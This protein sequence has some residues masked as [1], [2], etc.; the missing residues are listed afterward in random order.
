MAGF[1][2]GHAT[3]WFNHRERIRHWISR[4][5]FA[6][7]L[8]TPMV[9]GAYFYFD[10]RWL[11]FCGLASLAGLLVS[12]GVLYSVTIV[13][14]PLSKRPENA[15]QTALKVEHE[16][17]TVAGRLYPRS[18]LL[19]GWCIDKAR[20][21]VLR[22]SNAGDL[23]I[24]QLTPEH[25]AEL[26][27]CFGLGLT[28]RTLSLPIGSLATS[29]KWTGCMILLLVAQLLP[30][31]LIFAGGAPA[32]VYE[33]VTGGEQGSDTSLLGRMIML[34]VYLA[35]TFCSWFALWKAI[36]F[37]QRRMVTVGTDGVRVAGLMGRR[38]YRFS[39]TER[40]DEEGRVGK[41]VMRDGEEISLYGIDL[42]EGLLDRIYEG[43][44]SYKGLEH[45]PPLPFALETL[46]RDGL[47][48]EAWKERLLTLTKANG[49][50]RSA[51][52]DVEQ[53]AEIVENA[54]LEP[55][56]RI[57]AALAAAA[58]GSELIIRRVLVAARATA[59]PNLRRGLENAARGR[60]D[61]R[62]LRRPSH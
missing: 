37:F 31:G 22:T 49:G 47:E 62:A 58:G 32:I 50:Y 56:Y 54:F 41:L 42:G 35:L 52:A 38:F 57:G 10:A 17:L 9:F 12:H 5:A 2:V 48:P 51:S 8:C 19:Q 59:E 60:I 53:L 1:D 6:L 45:A 43:W 3:T 15:T 14:M 7:F 13:P 25:R 55:E 29:S 23:V 39:A 26:L 27:S 24:E 36:R 40:I 11:L 46:A 34:S 30:F 44:R 20:C 61:L 18:A 28:Q 16:S 4:L 21:I 33:F